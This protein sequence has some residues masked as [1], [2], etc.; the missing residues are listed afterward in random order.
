MKKCPY[1]AEEIQDEAIVCRFCGRDL[2]QNIQPSPTQ[3]QQTPAQ[4]KQGTNPVQTLLVFLGLGVFAICGCFVVLSIVA[5]PDDSDQA[6]NVRS[7]ISTEMQSTLTPLAT[8]VPTITPSALTM[9]EIE[10]KRENFTE[11]QWEEYEKSLK[12]VRVHWTGSVDQVT[13]DGTVYLDV[14]ESLFHGVYLDGLPRDT[15]RQLNKGQVIEFEATIKNVSTILGLAIRLD[16]PT[17]ISIR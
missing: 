4:S 7:E 1:C 15:L 2:Q 13:E 5:Q 9:Q 3:Q 6:A 14:G 16:S 17:I 12:G 11:I 10:E 8:R